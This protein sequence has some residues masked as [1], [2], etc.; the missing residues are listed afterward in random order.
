ML[1]TPDQNIEVKPLIHVDEPSASQ[2]DK[3]IHVNQR[4]LRALQDALAKAEESGDDVTIPV[5]ENGRWTHLNIVHGT[6]NQFEC[7]VE[8][9]ELVGSL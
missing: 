4:G 3:N 7:G 6:H 1:R 5:F 8:D 2:P 9:A